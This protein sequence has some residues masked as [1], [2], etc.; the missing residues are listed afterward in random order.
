MAAEPIVVSWSELD[1]GRQCPH[2]WDLAWQQRWRQPEDAEESASLAM[3]TLGHRVLE[4]H[5][6]ALMDG[7]TLS[8]ARDRGLAELATSPRSP[9]ADAIEWVYGRFIERYGAD[10]Q[11]RILGVEERLVVPLDSRFH[12]KTRVDLIVEDRSRQNALVFVDWKFSGRLLSERELAFDDQFGLYCAALAAQGRPVLYALYGQNRV[13]PK[14][15]LPQQLEQPL[16]SWFERVP[17]YRTEHEIDTIIDE[18]LD[19][20][21]ALYNA[22]TSGTLPRRPDTD[23]CK[24]RCRFTYPCLHG[25]KHG[26]DREIELLE[27]HG[28]VQDHTRH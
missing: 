7:A 11:W 18:A 25:R 10:R 2:K 23:R 19:E 17:L 14:G 28:F 26:D 13:P 5:Y 24:W 16:E 20:Y 6:R 22:K 9:Y 27:A 4:A 8:T 15:R 21:H 3:G 1:D 12:L